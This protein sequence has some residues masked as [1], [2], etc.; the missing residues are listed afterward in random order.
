MTIKHRIGWMLAGSAMMAAVVGAVVTL[1]SEGID[2]C[3]ITSRVPLSNGDWSANTDGCGWLTLPADDPELAGRVL[4]GVAYRFTT[5]WS[6]VQR[7]PV[8]RDACRLH[9]DGYKG[10]RP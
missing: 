4:D 9:V 1:P 3:T 2:D 6:W 8:I 10:P 7:P 5:D